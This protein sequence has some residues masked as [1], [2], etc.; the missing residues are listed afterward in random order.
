MKSLA[1]QLPQSNSY[2]RGHEYLDEKHRAELRASGINDAMIAATGIHSAGGEAVQKILGWGPRSHS[3]PRSMVIPFRDAVGADGDFARVKPDFPRTNEKG[4]AIKYESPRGKPNRAYFPP[5]FD[6]NAMTLLFVEGEKKAIASQQAGFATIGL[7]G[8]YG[9]QQARRRTDAGKAYGKR[10]LIPD[11]ASIN[12]AGRR[13]VIVY[14]SDVATNQGVKLAAAKLAEILTERGAKVFAAT[15]SAA[16]DGAKVGVDDFLFAR[17]DRGPEE[18]QRLLDAAVP[19][20]VPELGVMDFARL[21]IDEQ[22]TADNEIALRYWREE[23]YRW[24]GTRYVVI[25]DKEL[26]ALVLRWL[27]AISPSARPRMAEEVVGCLQSLCLVSFAV[28]QP[29]FLGSDQNVTPCNVVSFNNGLLDTSGIGG[30]L[31]LTSHTPLWF[32]SVSLDYPFDPAANCPNWEAFLRSI[33]SD[34]DCVELLQRFFGLLLTPDTSFQKLLLMLGPPRAGKGVIVRTMQRVFGPANCSSPTLSSLS[35]TFGLWP[36]VGKSIAFLPDAHLG[37]KTDAT[38]VLETIKS[39]TGE[40]P[41]NVNRKNMSFLQNVR[42]GVRFVVCANE[43]FHFSD[44]SGA[45]TP[46][47]LVLPFDQSFVG[48]EDRTIE[49]RLKPESPG[50]LNWSLVG[51]KKLRDAGGFI[52]PAASTAILGNYSRLSCPVGAFIDDACELGPDLRVWTDDIWH[53]WR[54][55]AKQ[56][57]REA[58]SKETFGERLRVSTPSVTRHRAGKDECRR[59]FY[60]GVALTPAGAEL[61]ALGAKCE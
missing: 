31:S 38:A 44:A 15:L 17:G 22:C 18:L 45:L 13:V 61:A 52:T 42:I 21:F 34:D 2:R 58:G 23:F 43:L 3:W 37:R 36:L 5:G 56:N 46:R 11:L 12:W 14:D 25:P 7:V 1:P 10:E 4:K 6:V 20:E 9:F 50:I 54:A 32:S 8:V 53:A 27:D 29:V 59:Y 24:N 51:L 16:P 33:F 47:L 48:R 40:D 39:I 41:Q 35:S 30:P 28:E 60:Q 26:R 19:A 55:W 49:D 57:G